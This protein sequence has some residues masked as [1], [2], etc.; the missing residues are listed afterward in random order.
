MNTKAL[1]KTILF[2]VIV[3][4]IV[5]VCGYVLENVDRWW[6]FLG[7]FGLVALAILS[8]VVYGVYQIFAD[9]SEACPHCNCEKC[10]CLDDPHNL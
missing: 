10:K 9:E 5:V 7:G 6:I 2:F 8:L 3:I 1:L 4:L